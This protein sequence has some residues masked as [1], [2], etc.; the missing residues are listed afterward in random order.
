MEDDRGTPAFRPLYRQVRET[1]VQRLIDGT[2]TPGMLLPSEFQIAAELGVSQGTV[3]KALDA[4]AGENL[5]VRRQGRGTFV[6]MPE[7]SRI[8]F[9]FFRLAADDGTRLFPE[10]RVHGL[11]R[12]PAG[13]V[14][15]AA[16]AIGPNDEVWRIDRVRHLGGRPVIVEEIVLPVARF[17]TLAEMEDIP[18]NVY[19]LYSERFQI[20]IGRA[21]EKLK[22]DA[23][24]NPTAERLGC[25]PGHP[26]LVIER[27]ASAL[28]G[29]PVEWRISRCLTDGFHYRADLR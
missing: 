11:A 3:R 18:N 5:L 17:P 1:L 9:Q 10:S 4:M 21:M 19:A 23:A 6:A 24:D 12:E 7:E 14:A 8:L 26:I 13:N 20:T 29:S 25:A 16:L 2:W 15:A 22:A 27:V 28:D